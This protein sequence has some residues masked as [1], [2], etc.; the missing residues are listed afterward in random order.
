MNNK[1]LL[2]SQHFP[3]EIGAASNRM[4]HLVSRLKGHGYELFVVTASPSYPEPDLYRGVELD[5]ADG[6]I[7]V[8]RSPVIT[9]GLKGKT[10]RIVNQLLFL[11]YALLMAPFICLRYSVRVCLTTS[12]PFPVNLVGLILALVLRVKWVMDVRDLWPDS[13]LAVTGMSDKSVIYR[14]LKKLELLFY[15]VSRAIVVVT[16]RSKE[17]LVRQGVPP[18][19]IQVITNGIPDWTLG[20]RGAG[21]S[22]GLA[23]GEPFRVVYIGNLGYAQQLEI[24]LE[25]AR[26]LQNDPDI[27]FY[28]VG[29]GLAK[30]DLMRY[31]RDHQLAHVHFIPAQTDKQQLLK[32]YRQAD[33]GIVSLKQSP[34][35]ATVIPSKVFEY[36]ALGIPILYIGQGEGAEL[37][38]KY[39]LG[40]RVDYDT[41]AIKRAILDRARHKDHENRQ[42]E[43]RLHR[44]I[45]D[46]SWDALI[47]KY[48]KILS[49]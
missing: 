21:Q 34:L 49:S 27:R 19:K 28:F 1:L 17:M 43:D 2:V 16:R 48:L 23:A 45:Q 5:D 18:D 26:M 37:V 47:H 36:G 15:R 30:P 42:Q 40:K 29:E 44:F 14:L 13:L 4:K 12:P 33:L 10:A 38:E 22:A 11:F 3:P 7:R 9:R 41:I 20:Y 6:E 32:W 46:F 31:V 25:A 8:F 24:V 39:G 35:F